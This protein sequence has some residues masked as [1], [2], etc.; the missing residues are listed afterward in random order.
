MIF[1]PILLL[2]QRGYLETVEE[3]YP[4]PQNMSLEIFIDVDAGEV[5]VDR[6]SEESSVSVLMTYTRNE[7]RGMVAYREKDHAQLRVSLE[8][9][10]WH[11]SMSRDRDIWADLRIELPYEVD[12]FLNSKVKAGEIIMDLGDI[13][14]KEFT[15]NNWAGE[16]EVEFLDPNRTTLDFLD[17]KN[18]V[19]EARLLKLGNARFQEADINSG[20]GELEIDFSGALLSGSRAVV[21]L[22]IG[23]S[24]ICLPWDVGSQVIID[25]LSFLSEKNFDSSF[26]KRGRAYYTDD[27]DDAGK[28]FYLRVSPGLGELSIDRE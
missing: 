24:Y 3:T 20:I 28:R 11:R 7:F 15:L 21:D 12:I 6:G 5:T 16:V 9:K 10:S 14:L 19:G 4:I 1:F 2:G 23:E 26:Y 17:I 27:Y 13:H 8:K 25:G 18:K 22:D